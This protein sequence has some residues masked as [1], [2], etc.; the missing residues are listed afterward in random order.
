MGCQTLRWKIMENKLVV[1][2]GSYRKNGFTK[3][4]L[5]AEARRLKKKHRIKKIKYFFLDNQLTACIH[6]D[7]CQIGCVIQDQFQEIAKEIK[8]AERI[9]LG[10]P[11]YLDFPSPKLLA[12][13]SRLNCYAESTE[14]EFFRGKKVHFVATAYCS[15][16]KTVIHALMGACEM[17][18]F[19]IEG[20]SSKEY[21]QLWKDKKIR[22]G[23]KRK[24]ACF[25]NG[26]N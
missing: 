15:G 24:D 11:V 8:D 20:R 14:R 9:L 22:G 21:I 13:L 1:I 10:S 5:D 7:H 18:G 23:M 17:L 4:C 3:K 25:L 26:G 12:F 16:T 2:N 19:T 6:C